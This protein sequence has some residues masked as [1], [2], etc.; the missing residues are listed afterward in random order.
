L[1][2]EPQIDSAYVATGKVL[3]VFR[4]FPLSFHQDALPGAKAAWCAGQQGAALFWSM[5]DWLFA[6]QNDWVQLA[7][8]DAAKKFRDQA[9]A[10]GADGAK[11]DA[12][13]AASDSQ[14]RIMRDESDGSNMGVQGTP[15]FFVNDWFVDGAVPFDQFKT[16][17]DKALQGQH[18]APT[19]TPLP[20]GAQFYDENPARPGFTYANNP[21]QGQAK[22]PMVLIAFE[23]LKCSDCALFS[24]TVLPQLTDKYVKTG[25]LRLVF[26]FVASGANGA[27]KAAVASLCA[28]DQN[29]FWDY[30]SSLFDHQ[31]EWRD[32]DSAA[33]TGYATSLGLDKAKFAQCLAAAPGQST[34]DDGASLAQQVG[35]QQLPYF[36]L[37]DAEKQQAMRIPG[38]PT[39]Q[40]FDSDVQSVR[41]PPT[42][43]P[44][45]GSTASAATPASTA[46]PAATPTATQ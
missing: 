1:Q 37:L 22:A 33:F 18:P 41:N 2:T 17:I 7:A 14:A 12:C 43:T 45:A 19:A 4:N 39:L 20:A 29:K 30:T 13:V 3:F 42:A 27:P 8:T 26:E 5:H 31:S 28:A 34:V 25:Q 36:V 11:Y 10:F 46:A 23:D 44:A 6:N 9:V 24:K 38:V 21:S 40:Q 16:T 32:G 35:I 15:A